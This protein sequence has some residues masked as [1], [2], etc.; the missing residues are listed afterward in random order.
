ME[1]DITGVILE[2]ERDALKRWGSGDPDGFLEISAT[3][4]SYFDPMQATRL[5]G[6][7]RLSALYDTIRGK[8]K[9]D[10]SEIVNPRVQ[11]AGDAAVL[12]YQFIS[13][14]SEGTMRWNSTAV[15]QRDAGCWRIIHS[16]W[17]FVQPVLAPKT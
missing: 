2:L 8:I 9:I 1:N 6:L 17:S 10:S 7:D 12:T 16:H 5:D 14:G 13:R 11:I 4:V 3:G 15:Y